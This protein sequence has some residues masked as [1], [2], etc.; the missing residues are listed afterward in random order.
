MAITIVGCGWLGLPLGKALVNKGYQVSGSVTSESK[1]GALKAAGIEPFVFKLNPEPIGDIEL[2]LKA[3]VLILSI[4][5]RIG[6]FG[7]QHHIEQMNSLVSLV[8]SHPQAR[9]Q[10]IIYISS[11]SVYPERNR[12]ITEN[13]EVIHNSPLISAEN[14]LKGMNFPLTILRCGGL[15]GY[16]R[17]PGKY[18]IGKQVNTG[19]TPVN[20][21]H[22][23]DV[24]GIIE[25]IIEQNLWNETLN[26]VAPEHPLR[27]DIY[28]KNAA[29]FGWQAPVFVES[30]DSIPYKIISSTKL[31][32]KLGYRFQYP[33]PLDFEYVDSKPV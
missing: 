9:T 18:F 12:E 16:D 20:F 28:L 26:A 33:N 30:T 19:E 27:R 2:I 29:Q 6:Q 10:S 11:T 14:V 32:N 13:D 24:I 1:F 25:Q 5:P 23:E 21:I 17:I 4:P 31:I 22:Q 7:D 3:T 8:S 15:M